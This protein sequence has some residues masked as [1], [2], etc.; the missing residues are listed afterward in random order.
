MHW[1]VNAIHGFLQAAGVRSKCSE[2]RAARSECNQAGLPPSISRLVVLTIYFL[3]PKARIYQG[4]Q[5][6]LSNDIE[7]RLLDWL[8]PKLINCRESEEEIQGVREQ[9]IDTFCI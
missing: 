8:V 5:G 3:P 1:T 4:D 2:A 9:H 7:S 6:D